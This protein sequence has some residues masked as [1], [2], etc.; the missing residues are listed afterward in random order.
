M[1][2]ELICLTTRIRVSQIDET[3][4]AWA[5]DAKWLYS[6]SQGLNYN[7]DE[8]WWLRG[9]GNLTGP[10]NQDEHFMVWMRPTANPDTYHLWGSIDQDLL[11]GDQLT[12]AVHN[13]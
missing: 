7:T 4:L 10:M 6:N 2:H 8:R 11:P 13:R 9:G 5:E 1:N 12:L 3:G